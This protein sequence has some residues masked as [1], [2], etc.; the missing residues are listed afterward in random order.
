MTNGPLSDDDAR[1]RELETLMDEIGSGSI[2]DQSDLNEAQLALLREHLS[3][4]ELEKLFDRTADTN[5]E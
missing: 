1:R 4:E 3:E 5:R 2:D